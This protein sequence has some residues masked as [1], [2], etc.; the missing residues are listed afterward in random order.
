[1]LNPTRLIWTDPTTR[2]D[3]SPFVAADFKAYELGVRDVADFT[4]LLVLP[5]AFGVG[6]SPIPDAIKGRRRSVI[7]LR[8]IDQQDVVSAWSTSVEVAFV[9]PPRPVSGFAAV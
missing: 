6:E 8:T 7:A 4:P 5:T 1:M 9:G 2:E 3:D